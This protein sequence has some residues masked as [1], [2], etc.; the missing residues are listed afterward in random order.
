MIES[1]EFHACNLLAF[2]FET[3]GYRIERNVIFKE[4]GTNFH[5]DGWDE[6]ARVGFE[7]LT[8]EDDDHDDLDLEEYKVIS[9][10]QGRNE[11]A[12]FIVD[13]VKP[14]SE[15]HLLEEANEF[16][17]E[18]ESMLVVRKPDVVVPV[19]NADLEENQ[20]QQNE[21]EAADVISEYV[22][23]VFSPQSDQDVDG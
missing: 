16:L 2:L 14:T 8:S 11:L 19:A 3:R 17:D 20:K 6:T 12:I 9:A 13:E 18:I 21:D 4:Y 1:N 22:S 7:F 5:L 10:A 23:A 15:E